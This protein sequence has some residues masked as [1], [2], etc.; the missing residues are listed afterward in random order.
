M[1]STLKSLL[2]PVRDA[3]RRARPLRSWRRVTY[4]DGRQLY[5]P[6]RGPEP[7]ADLVFVIYHGGGFVGGAPL[8]NAWWATALGRFGTC[9]LVE[10][11][12]FRST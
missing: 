1:I 9:Y 5:T 8:D 2:R 4:G 7:E 6:R 10:Y 12:T 3:V 11:A